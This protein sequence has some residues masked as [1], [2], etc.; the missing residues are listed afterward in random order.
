MV[1]YICFLALSI[2]FFVYILEHK[3]TGFRKYKCENIL[4]LSLIIFIGGGIFY[5]QVC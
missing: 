2:V 1:N 5:F 4:I 3:E